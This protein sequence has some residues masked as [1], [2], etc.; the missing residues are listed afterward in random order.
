MDFHIQ[1]DE[2]NKGSPAFIRRPIVTLSLT[3]FP[4]PSSPFPHG[5]QSKDN[6]SQTQTVAAA[7]EEARVVEEYFMWNPHVV[8]A[9]SAAAAASDGDDGDDDGL[10]LISASPHFPDLNTNTAPN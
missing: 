2:Q 8:L 1:Y 7:K 10:H 3:A 9:P 6:C 5:R 4:S